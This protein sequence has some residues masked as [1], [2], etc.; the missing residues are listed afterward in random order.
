MW[1]K[2]KYP[3]PKN[4]NCLKEIEGVYK[5]ILS[6]YLIISLHGYELFILGIA[7][8]AEPYFKLC[9]PHSSDLSV[10]YMSI[11]LCLFATMC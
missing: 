3:I 7:H 4:A 6:R 11:A 5:G 1:C 10:V 9:Y 2:L 8:S